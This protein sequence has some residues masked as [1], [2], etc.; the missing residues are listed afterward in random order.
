MVA[1]AYRQAVKSWIRGEMAKAKTLTYFGRGEAGAV[2][3]LVLWV[4]ARL[5]MHLAITFLTTWLPGLIAISAPVVY[6]S[7]AWGSYRL[8]AP[9]RLYDTSNFRAHDIQWFDNIDWQ[10]LFT[11]CN[12]IE[13]LFTSN[14]HWTRVHI[15]RI[16]RFLSEK[17]N[18]LTIVIRSPAPDS[19]AGLA[20]RFSEDAKRRFEKILE[21]AEI[22]LAA[23]EQIPQETRGEFKLFHHARDATHS[24]YRFGDT[25]LFVPY[26]LRPGWAPGEVP[27]LFFSTAD[28][29]YREFLQR[30]F[31]YL[32]SPAGGAQPFTKE[33]LAGL[34]KNKEPDRGT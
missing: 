7:L 34:L 8:K 3:G 31:A 1:S 13:A 29:F 16:K 17:D 12:R 6:F 22:L 2:I 33:L 23:Y 4:I 14:T 18:F 5:S 27:V 20:T 15:D 28:A 24:Y 9:R 32:S 19:L 10:K 21:T 11:N 30:D 26:K 25:V